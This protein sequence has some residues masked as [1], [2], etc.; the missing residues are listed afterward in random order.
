[1]TLECIRDALRAFTSDWDHSPGRFNLLEIEGR[2][3]LMDYC[4]NVHGLQ[5]IAEFVRLTAAPRTIGVVAI[6][7][8]RRDQDIRDFGE[9]AGRTFDELVIREHDD[10]RGRQPGEVAQMLRDAA[11]RAGMPPERVSVVLD[12]L[13]AI[14]AAIDRAAPGDLV[15]ALVYRIQRARDALVRRATRPA[16]AAAAA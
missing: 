10:P 8:D 15:V 11:I 1:M 14:D 4:H 6:A 2:Q 13:E 5:G 16:A 12:E 9:L 3:V 7:G